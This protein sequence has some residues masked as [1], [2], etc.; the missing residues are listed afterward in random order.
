MPVGHTHDIGSYVACQI[1]LNCLYNRQAG[2][3]SLPFLGVEKI[4][5]SFK[6]TGMGIE[7]VAVILVTAR[8]TPRF[9]GKLTIELCM[10]R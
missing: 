2:N 3:G 8:E 1:G 6:K 9:E 7:D 10:H 5:S 4:P